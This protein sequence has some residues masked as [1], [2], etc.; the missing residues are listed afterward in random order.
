MLRFSADQQRLI[1]NQRRQHEHQH[2]LMQQQYGS[3][4][5][6]NASPLPRDVWGRWDEE[7]IE[8]QREVLAVFD[9]LSESLSMDMPIG[10]MMHFFRTESDSGNVN[11]SMDGRSRAKTDQQ[12][13]DYHGTPLPIIDSTFSYGWRQ[14]EAA[15]SEGMPLD[16]VGR[17]NAMRRVAEKLESLALDGDSQ[18]RVGSDQLYGLRTHPMRNTRSTTATLAS[19]TGAEVKDDFVATLGLLHAANFRVPAT[20]Y[21][22]WD[23]WFYWST[24]QYSTQYPN[25]TILERLQATPMVENIIPASNVNANELIAVVKSRRVVQVLN[26]MPLSTRALF[27]ANPEDDYDFVTMAA[28]ALEVRFDAEEQCG[29]AHSS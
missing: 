6:G 15:Q 9:D 17:N 26:G 1:L 10:K 24:A 16:P 2:R 5:I 28:S 14:V 25:W 20:F 21:V 12:L 23:D 4:I 7:G 3:H 8:V 27:R 22:N 13:I 11:I 19:A 18:I 29:I